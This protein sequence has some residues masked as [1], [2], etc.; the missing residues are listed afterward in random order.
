MKIKIIKEHH[1]YKL[2]SEL[3]VND[4]RANYL[5]KCGIAIDNSE[6]Y[7]ISTKKTIEEADKEIKTANTKKKK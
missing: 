7:G 1:K 2:G 5:I 6:T 4:V 3:S